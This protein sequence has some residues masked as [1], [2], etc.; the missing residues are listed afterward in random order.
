MRLVLQRVQQASI[1]SE[2]KHIAEIKAGLLVFL[3]IGKNDTT[4]IFPWVIDKLINLRI[5]ED[6]QGKMN[7]SVSDIQ[8]EIL[9]VSQFTL[10]GNCLKGRRPSFIEGAP[11]EEAKVLYEAFVTQLKASY[12]LV[13]EGIFQADMKISLINDG[14]VTFIIEKN[15]DSKN[16]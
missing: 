11:I 9:V 16:S 4:A 7:N 10:Y 14:P 13:K 1:T 3:G 15:N 6:E 2:S 5:F 8:G 12:K